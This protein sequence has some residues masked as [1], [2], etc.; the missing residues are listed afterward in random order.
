MLAAIET[1]LTIGPGSLAAIAGVVL[2]IVFSMV[3]V[4]FDVG[5]IRGMLQTRLEVVERKA[6][7]TERRVDAHAEKLS[8]LEAVAS[9]K[10]LTLK[11]SI[12]L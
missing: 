3:K 10:V 2:T 1:N 7:E 6:D 8:A 9:T 12:Q 11:P 5:A 4:A